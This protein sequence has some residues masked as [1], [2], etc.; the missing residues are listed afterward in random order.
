MVKPNT[1]ERKGNGGWQKP[2]GTGLCARNETR[3]AAVRDDGPPIAALSRHSEHHAML[4]W[5][6]KADVPQRGRLRVQFP[7]WNR[8]SARAIAGL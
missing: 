6:W 8:R 4:K 2:H 7:I 5:P 1:A 3:A